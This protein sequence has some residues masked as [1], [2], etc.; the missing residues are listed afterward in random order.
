MEVT[1]VVIIIIIIN[2]I[3]I[4][5]KVWIEFC[6]VGNLTHRAISVKKVFQT[7]NDSDA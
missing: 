4:I 1:V 3:I 7:F 5:K 2:I 6:V